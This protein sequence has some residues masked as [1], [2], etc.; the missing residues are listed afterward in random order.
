MSATV[1]PTTNREFLLRPIAV[2]LV[3]ALLSPYPLPGQQPAAASD[4]NRVR[5]LPPG[6]L[7][8]VKTKAGDA[9]HGE[10]VGTNPE[11]VQ[12][13]SDERGFP[14]RT[15]RRRDL[16]QDDVLEIRR[17]SRG[18]SALVSAGI[19]AG[20]GAGIGLAIDLSAR[21]NEDRGLAT[22]LFVLLGSLLGWAIGRH[23]TLAKGETIYSAP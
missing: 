22:V 14:G 20:V 7:I 10:L 13:D 23:S 1:L 6:T 12:L 11:S 18:R 2:A 19:G 17:L 21:S 16:R 9:Y 8:W 15:T 3:C 5:N 4:W